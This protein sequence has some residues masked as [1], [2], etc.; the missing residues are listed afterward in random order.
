MKTLI[1]IID[2]S[3][4][5]TGP[6]FVKQNTS[7]RINAK[8]FTGLS[9]NHFKA[10]DLLLDSKYLINCANV[11]IHLIDLI[12]SKRQLFLHDWANKHKFTCSILVDKTKM[13]YVFW[14]SDSY[15]QN[16]Q[17]GNDDAI[18]EAGAALDDVDVPHR[19]RIER[20]GVDGEGGKHCRLVIEDC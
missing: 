9:Q 16:D 10:R 2:M 4:R 11:R 5:K 3:P 15:C 8:Y 1:Y 17:H 7:N 20:A 6:V 12:Y 18:E 13:F 14:N 19:D